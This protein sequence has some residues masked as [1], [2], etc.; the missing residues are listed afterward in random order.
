[1]YKDVMEFQKAYPTKEEKERALAQMSDEEI[2]R[3]ACT[4]TNQT[5]RAW[6]AEHMKDQSYGITR[7]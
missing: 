5:G 2:W 4:C 3:L 7:S 1:M 6:Y